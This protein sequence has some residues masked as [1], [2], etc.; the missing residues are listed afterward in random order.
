MKYKTG[1]LVPATEKQEKLHKKHNI[2]DPNKIIV[3][4]SNTFKFTVN[5]LL[6][7]IRTLAYIIL[8]V[9]ATIGLASLIYPDTRAG[10]QSILND[11]LTE[12]N[13][14]L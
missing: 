11:I 8:F 10:L 2:S 14:L 1:I 6:S 4:K 5:L 7:L 13:I 9:L 3:E 12:L